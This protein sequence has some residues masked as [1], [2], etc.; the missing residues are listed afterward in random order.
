VAAG[1]AA[2]RRVMAARDAGAGRTVVAGVAGVA[3]AAGG[4]RVIAAGAAAGHGAEAGRAAAARRVPDRRDA[5]GRGGAGAREFTGGLPLVSDAS[6][7]A[8]SRPRLATTAKRDG[9][10][11][12]QRRTRDF[13]VESAAVPT[14]ATL[15]EV[16]REAQRVPAA[17]AP[18]GGAERAGDYGSDRADDATE[19]AFEG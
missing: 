11:T 3:R 16:R 9:R 8:A 14:S 13:T 5:A 19:F 4:S 6:P 1:S 10:G 15:E 18:S 7:A 17:S 12:P 2:E